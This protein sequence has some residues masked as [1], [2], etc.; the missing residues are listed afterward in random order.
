[1]KKVV[2]FLGVLLFVCGCSVQKVEEQKDNEKFSIEYNISKNN[3]FI[4]AKIDEVLFLLKEENG[5]LFL[6][7]S[8]SEWSRVFAK[9]L[10]QACKKTQIEKVYYFNLKQAKEETPKRY[11]KI[12][13]SIRQVLKKEEK[14]EYPLLLFIKSGKIINYSLGYVELSKDQN[15]DGVIKK[16]QQKLKKKY[17]HY[18]EEFQKDT[19]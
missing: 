13:K 16:E 2:L 8:D 9:I 18:I 7:D 1:M 17:I 12:V 19:N 10:N 15:E 4:Y 3:P 6:G 5:I 11:Q 14:L